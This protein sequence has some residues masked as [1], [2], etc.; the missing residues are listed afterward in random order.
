V[1]AISPITNC[2]GQATTHRV[3]A[4]HWTVFAGREGAAYNHHAQLTSLGDR[5]YATWSCG[6]G[7]EDDPGQQMVVATSDDGGETWSEPARISP[8]GRGQTA[9]ITYTAEGI[10]EYD[11]QLIATYGRYEWTPLG[12]DADGHR[13][14][15][16]CSRYADAPDVWVHRDV[17]TEV[18]VSSDGGHT[19]GEP[20]RAIERF[21]P[22]LRPSTIAGGRII[23]PGNVAYPF[24]DDS[25]G[26]SGW[27][28][29]G[30]PR[31]PEDVVDDPEGFHKACRHRG[32]ET[33]YCE[34]S[35]YQTH[36]SVVHMMLRTDRHRLAVTESQDRGETWSEPMWT[37]YTDCRCRFQFGHLPDGRFLGLSCPQPRSERTPMVLATS[38]DGIVFDRH[39]V[40]GA[41]PAGGPRLL[42]YHKGGRYGYPSYHIVGDT[43]YVIYS[44]HKE[45]IALCRF[46]LGALA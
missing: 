38:D 12:L 28:F 17:W 33:E 34:G 26:L 27:V 5:L 44:V 46:R 25:A 45:D 35:F 40:L 19:W 1:T 10:R 43:M 13:L 22:N 3:K 31:L 24:T 4:E 36:D 14:P 7:H 21:V 42:G 32:D 6:Y 37:G 15:D 8:A 16:A 9:E 23:C 41:A 29:S 30:L 39:Y 18:R 2:W 11:S 20:R